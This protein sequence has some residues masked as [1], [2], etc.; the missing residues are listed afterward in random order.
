[1]ISENTIKCTPQNDMDCYYNKQWKK[2][3]KLSD[4]KLAINNFTI[5]Q[6]RIDEDLYHFIIDS[7]FDMDPTLNNMIRFRNSYYN[8]KD[9]SEILILLI[10]LISNIRNKK[11]LAYVIKILT[12]L[13]IDT[14]FTTGVVPNFKDPDVYTLALGE[15]PLTFDSKETYENKN[16]K[17][18]NK[19]IQLLQGLYNFV[20]DKWFYKISDAENFIRNVITFEILFSKSNL[21]MEEL[22]DPLITH[23]SDDFKTFIKKFDS[24]DFWKTI[25]GKYNKSHNGLDI[26]VYYN[27][28]KALTFIKLFIEKLTMNELLMT[29]DYLVYCVLKKYGIYTSANVYFDNFSNYES[30]DKKIFMDMFYQTYGYYL[31]KVYDSTNLNPKKIKQITEMF[32]NMK[33]CCYKIIE[34]SDIFGPETKKEA[35]LKL[36]TLGIV[37]GQQ[38]Y[39]VDMSKLKISG[40]NFYDDFTKINLY[41]F[42]IM[43]SFIGKRTNR[44]YLSLDN[45]IFSFIVNAY[46][47]PPT[48]KI[49]IPTSMTNDLFFKLDVSDPIYNYGSLGSIIG[50]EIMHCFDNYGSL[51]DHRGHLNNWWT[52]KDYDKYQKEIYKVKN[53]Y[54]TLELYGLAINPDVSLAENIADIAGLKLSLRTYM[55]IY[56]PNVDPKNMSADEKKHLEKFFGRWVNTLRTNSSEDVIKYEIKYDVHPPSIIRVNAPFSHI[57]EYYDVYNVVPE[58]F[59]YLEPSKRTKFMD[60]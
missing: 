35:I 59:N 13:K 42:N 45:D 49:F 54:S 38:D 28:V 46:Y 47:D 5:V 30:D 9:T 43:M 10:S 7:D 21:S 18:I 34:K 58:D 2:Y 24:N 60:L 39:F 15:I 27:N 37:C 20:A 33:S 14:L 40:K 25:F 31:Q 12:S 57:N 29:K 16:S 55:Q 36:Q 50:H 53:H 11:E 4:D 44:N 22:V 8:K 19:F 48:N 51:F 56:I 41:Q 52:E 17:L 3:N 26:Y 32:D 23:N 1:M 6:D